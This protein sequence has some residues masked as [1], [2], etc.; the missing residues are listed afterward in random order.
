MRVGL[1]F[2]IVKPCASVSSVCQ[3]VCP[4]FRGKN[5]GTFHSP[6]TGNNGFQMQY[7]NSRC[8]RYNIL[9]L[10]CS[11]I[12]N[13]IQYYNLIHKQT[14]V[15]VN[16]SQSAV[17]RVRIS[18]NNIVSIFLISYK[19][20]FLVFYNSIKFSISSAFLLLIIFFINRQRICNNIGSLITKV[21]RLRNW[22]I[23]KPNDQCE[24]FLCNLEPCNFNN[25]T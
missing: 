24:I 13:I 6:S 1:L 2:C 19:T 10:Y 18:N 17:Q 22:H 9:E 7:H 15:F 16:W 25:L 5:G 3:P 20:T 8:G 4:L 11:L 12:V 23:A 21:R 14:K